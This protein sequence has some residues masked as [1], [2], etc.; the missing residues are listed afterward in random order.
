MYTC[1]CMHAC[2]CRDIYVLYVGLKSTAPEHRNRQP[3]ENKK[4]FRTYRYIYTYTYMYMYACMCVW[5]YMY[6][7]Y[8]W[9]QQRRSVKSAT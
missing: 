8:D 6:H 3:K 1:T 9:S 7:M 4:K 5:R 2:V